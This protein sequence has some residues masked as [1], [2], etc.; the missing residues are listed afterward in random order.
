MFIILK[1][2]STTII[3]TRDSVSYCEKKTSKYWIERCVCH[4][5]AGRIT[6][7]PILD[8]YFSFMIYIKWFVYNV[9][10]RRFLNYIYAWEYSKQNVLV[11]CM[12]NK[13][14]TCIKSPRW[15]PGATSF[16]KHMNGNLSGFGR[17]NSNSYVLPTSP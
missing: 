10:T 17:C 3:V 4:I 1:K 15:W 9:N 16:T 11:Y 13:T 5:S 7:F 14:V 12:R 6:H 8:Y 2:I